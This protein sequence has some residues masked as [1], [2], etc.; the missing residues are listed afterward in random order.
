MKQQVL[1]LLV[2]LF[3]SV[4]NVTAQVVYPEGTITDSSTVDSSALMRVKPVNVATDIIVLH[5]GEKL[6]VDVKKIQ[7]NDLYYTFPKHQ[8]ILEMDKRLVKKVYYKSGK[9]ETLSQADE[10]IPDVGDYRK[11][12]VTRDKKDVEKFLEVGRFDAKAEGSRRRNT[13]LRSLERSAEIILRRKAALLNAHI[14]LVI[15]QQSSMAFGEVPST[16]L[17]GVAYAHPANIDK[18]TLKQ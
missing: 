16:T 13:S 18:D 3:A 7:L 10:D 5:T 6:Y 17:T 12:K 11:V 9:I 14:V 1:W 4:V 15:D 8:E 2:F